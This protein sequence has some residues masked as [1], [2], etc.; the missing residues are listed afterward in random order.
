MVLKTDNNNRTTVN[1]D[2][3]SYQREVSSD[4]PTPPDAG[5]D[6]Y[7]PVRTKVFGDPTTEPDY[8][9]QL[10]HLRSAGG[11]V[12][13]PVPSNTVVTWCPHHRGVGGR[14]DNVLFY[15]GTVKRLEM[16]QEGSSCIAGR[17]LVGWRRVSD[18]KSANSNGEGAALATNQ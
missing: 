5:E 10:I 18:C 2:F 16:T 7:L 12:D 8:T 6:T 3:L 4:T 9:R 15:D 17:T 11:Y 1:L 14:P 13:V